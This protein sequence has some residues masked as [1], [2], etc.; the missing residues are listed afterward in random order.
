V[1][2]ALAFY[3]LATG[4]LEPFAGGVLRGRVKRGKEDPARLDERLGRPTRPRPDGALVWMHG[5]S[6]GEA[7][8]LLPLVERFRAERPDVAVLVTSGTVTSAEMMAKR[9]PAGAIH[10]YVPV[11]APGAAAR[12]IEHWRPSLGVFVES[13][14]WPNLLTAA[15]RCGVKLA[16]VSARLGDDSASGWRRAPA[17]A[18]RLLEGFDLVLPQDDVQAQRLAALGARDDG[19]L[20]L[21]F[22]GEP[23]PVDAKALA[24]AKAAIGDRPMILAASTHPGEDALILDAF[25]RAPTSAAPLLVI[26]P[27]HPVRGPEIATLAS[28][29]GFT[30]T[31][32]SRGEDV[33]GAQV[34]VADT[35]GELGLWFTLARGALIAGSLVPGVGGHNPLEAIRLG[36]PVASGPYVDDWR[37]VYGVLTDAGDVVVVKTSDDL[38]GFFNAALARKDAA[39][40]QAALA[41][42]ADRA[43]VSP[44]FAKLRALLP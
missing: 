18:R 4:A 29:R 38:A 26:V 27:R 8:S 3:R 1:S 10:Q 16:L 14:L 5:A 39:T 37:S 32:R 17:M 9:L 33:A 43:D 6:V 41:L 24:D 35:L 2:A 20:N 40:A 15:R 12:F 36:C 19:R 22:A 25:A 28:A 34:H 31:L 42:I 13:E 21:K 23:L 7:V 11:D 44:A 30:T